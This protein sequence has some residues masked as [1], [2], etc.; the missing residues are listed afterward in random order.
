MPELRLSIAIQRNFKKQFF[1]EESG[2]TLLMD[3]EISDN[4]GNDSEAVS[5]TPKLIS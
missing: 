3:E 5:K 1:L 4:Q 2:L